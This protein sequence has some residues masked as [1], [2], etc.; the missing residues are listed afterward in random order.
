VK[1]NCIGLAD[2]LCAYADG[3]ITES[4]KQIVDDHLAICENCSAILKV[5]HEISTSMSYTNVSAPEALRIGVMNRI[6]SEESPRKVENKKKQRNFQ[7]MLKRYAP[8]AACLVVVLLVWQFWGNISAIFPAAAPME[9]AMNI[10]TVPAAA[11]TE[12]MAPEAAAETSFDTT[13]DFSFNADAPM[14]AAG[15]SGLE[16]IDGDSMSTEEDSPDGR[17]QINTDMSDDE[18]DAVMEYIGKAYAEIVIT[19]QLPESLT[20]G[21]SQ[22]F[23]LLFGWDMIFEIPSAEVQALTDELGSRDDVSITINSENSNSEYALVFYSNPN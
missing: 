2:L 1:T 11:P 13:D 8:I 10:T 4:N 17:A 7:I 21:I 3:E 16:S 5:Y 12:Q 22:P 23:A 19:G 20:E 6:Q 18:I 14:D 9:D 15:D